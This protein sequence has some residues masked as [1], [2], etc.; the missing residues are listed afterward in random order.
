VGSG[1]WRCLEI[2]CRAKC[3][4]VFTNWS[5]AIVIESSANTNPACCPTHNIARNFWMSN[6][7][8]GHLASHVA[9]LDKSCYVLP[10]LA[11]C[12][13]MPKLSFQLFNLLLLF[14]DGIEHG[15]EDWIAVDHQVALAV[16]SDSFRDDL[17]HC[18]S[19]K[20]N[21]FSIRL[22]AEGIVL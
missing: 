3:A 17:L 14:L 22:K 18:L 1:S 15:P 5:H 19:S 20:A 8:R 16:L 6:R 10:V 2:F 11:R 9:P 12:P 21:V 7:K 13:Q 4:M